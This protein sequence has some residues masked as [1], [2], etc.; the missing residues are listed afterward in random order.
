MFVLVRSL[1]HHK[2]CDHMLR[3]LHHM[4]HTQSIVQYVGDG[5]REAL[6]YFPMSATPFIQRP[7]THSML[8]TTQERLASRS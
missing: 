2:K 6:F 7:P 5:Q 4:S 3:P 1:M 8:I